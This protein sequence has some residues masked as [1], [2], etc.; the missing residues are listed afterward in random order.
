MADEVSFIFTRFIFIK[1][2]FLEFVKPLFL[3]F[4]PRFLNIS[5]NSGEKVENDKDD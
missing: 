4:Q 3:F 5:R 2:I 1:I